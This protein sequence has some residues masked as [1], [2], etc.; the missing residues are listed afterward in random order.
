MEAYNSAG[1][2]ILSH[3][4]LQGMTYEK[5][6]ACIMN[7]ETMKEYLVQDS[8]LNFTIISR[9]KEHAQGI[10]KGIKSHQCLENHHGVIIIYNKGVYEEVYEKAHASTMSFGKYYL[11]M[12][13][14]EYDS[15]VTVEECHDM[16]IGEIEKK[17][18]CHENHEVNVKEDDNHK[19]NN[20]GNDSKHNNKKKESEQHNKKHSSEHEKHH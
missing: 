2:A 19:Q 4:D 11:F 17:I 1:E 8:N 18:H 3:M 9:E 20:N 16:S 5:A 13:L 10:Q 7:H 12:K 14:Q 15:S 6:I